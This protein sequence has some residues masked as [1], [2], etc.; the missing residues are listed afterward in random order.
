MGIGV[1][2]LLIAV[3]AI[4]AF[5]VTVD[6]AS[7]YWTTFYTG[8]GVFKAPLAGGSVMRL[9]QSWPQ[10]WHAQGRSGSIAKVGA[11]CAPAALAV[12]KLS[13]PP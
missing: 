10:E 5:A 12:R 11:R 1:G 6:T 7:V 4:L 2:I 8:G 3:G 9:S 13:L